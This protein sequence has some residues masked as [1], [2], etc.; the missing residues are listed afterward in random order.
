MSSDIYNICSWNDN[1][2][3]KEDKQENKMVQINGKEYVTVAERLEKLHCEHEKVGI[4]TEVLRFDDEIVLV[5]AVL[6]IDDRE[7]VGHA[8]EVIGS[9]EVNSTSALEN[10]ETSGVG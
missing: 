9:S 3:N 7:F 4:Q 2:N 5:K 8:Q 1:E 10:A 6:S